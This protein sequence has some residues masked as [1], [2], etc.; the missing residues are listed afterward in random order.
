MPDVVEKIPL[1]IRLEGLDRQRQI[2]EM[3][4]QVEELVARAKLAQ[5]AA[6]REQIRL[7]RYISENLHPNP[8][9][10][11]DLVK[12]T[13]IRKEEME[14]GKASPAASSTEEIKEV[15]EG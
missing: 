8:E 4:V 14:N 12:G 11:I 2:R 10:S 9:D 1:K 15:K 3:L 13:I 7:D 5:T 6:E